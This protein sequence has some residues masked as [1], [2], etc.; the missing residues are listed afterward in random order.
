MKT[1]HSSWTFSKRITIVFE[2]NRF[3]KNDKRPFFMRLV[4]KRFSFK[5]HR[6]KKRSFRLSFFRRRFH[7]KT[8]IFQ[9][10]TKTIHPWLCISD[11]QYGIY[12]RIS[13]LKS[14]LFDPIRVKLTGKWWIEERGKYKH[15]KLLNILNKDR[16]LLNR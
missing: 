9:K 3:Y 7:N 11:Q 12:H 16:Q 1:T 10:K 15:R 6:F 5:N 2:N 4:L 14:T 8:I 13:S